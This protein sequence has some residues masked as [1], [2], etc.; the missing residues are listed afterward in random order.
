M[1]CST[2]FHIL[3]WSFEQIFLATAEFLLLE[4]FSAYFFHL[5]HSTMP[6]K[7]KTRE[8]DVEDFFNLTG[9]VSKLCIQFQN[10]PQN[11]NQSCQQVCACIHCIA[12]CMS[13]NK[14]IESISHIQCQSVMGFTDSDKGTVTS[15][16]SWGWGWWLI[17]LTSVA[18][19]PVSMVIM[20][21]GIEKDS[22]DRI[23]WGSSIVY[24]HPT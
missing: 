2:R 23:V 1:F 8:H 21:R 3:A 4:L 12:I 13:L 19:A 14:S 18:Q 9:K 11:V 7:G 5:L 16:V 6:S 20:W 24:Y 17:S 10:Q 22:V 15:S